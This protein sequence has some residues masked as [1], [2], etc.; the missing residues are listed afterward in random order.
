NTLRRDGIDARRLP[1]GY[2]PEWDHWHGESARR[3]IDVTFLGGYTSRRGKLI[4]RC[5]SVLEDRRTA[6]R[7]VESA[8]PHATKNG[9]FLEGARK[10]RHLA[11]AKIL[12]NVHRRST[13]YFEWLRFVEA[14]ANGCVVLSEH[15]AGFGPLVPGQHFASVAAESMPAALSTLLE[16]EDRQDAIRRE[17]YEFLQTELPLSKTVAAISEEIAEAGRRPVRGLPPHRTRPSPDPARE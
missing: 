12:L 10:Y 7:F 15:S 6:L 3:P 9:L 14:A 13:P 2:M 5:G 4:A 11:A 17:A 8:V 16:L 1:L